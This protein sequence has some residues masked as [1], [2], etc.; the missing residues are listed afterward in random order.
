MIKRLR[1]AW[2]WP[3]SK[4]RHA[5]QLINMFPPDT[6]RL[7]EPF[8]GS[9][10]VTLHWSGPANI[11]DISLELV[12]AHQQIKDHPDAVA[13]AYAGLISQGMDRD[14]YRAV[15][16]TAYPD[17]PAEMA[18]RLIYL[19]EL[20]WRGWYRRDKDG[21][22]NVGYGCPRP[23]ETGWHPGKVAARIVAHSAGLADTIIEHADYTRCY[24]GPKCLVLADPPYPGTERAYDAGSP[25]V[26]QSFMAAHAEQWVER[27]ADVMITLPDSETVRELYD[28]WWFTPLPTRR[29]GEMVAA[30]DLVIT[31][32][33][34]VHA[35]NPLFSHASDQ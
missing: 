9:A 28:G 31:S 34:P 29:R 13:D 19:Q 3:G 30:T 17:D 2:Q 21:R 10:A 6:V 18:A 23:G 32:Y 15:A 11:S 25:V 35:E 4:H 16:A 8:A 14:A 12:T 33:Q 20:G 27:G 24:A 7:F 1:P 22:S 26:H 5:R